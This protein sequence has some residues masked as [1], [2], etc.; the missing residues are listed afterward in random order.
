MEIYKC[1]IC[2]SDVKPLPRTGDHDGFDCPRHGKFKVG[3]TAL[4]VRA[5]ASSEQW[6]AALKTAKGRAPPD[7]WPIIS[8]DDFS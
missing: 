6:E 8:N 2:Q 4:V 7:E 5:G 1:P 3:G